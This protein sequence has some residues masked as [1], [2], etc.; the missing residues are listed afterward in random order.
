M[1]EILA[2]IE[3]MNDKLSAWKADPDAYSVDG[4][5]IWVL[6]DSIEDIEHQV[7]DLQSEIDIQFNFDHI[8]SIAQSLS[9]NI[10]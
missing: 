1:D 9:K 2:R 6:E 8:D 4:R 3:E 7:R 5:H 10:N